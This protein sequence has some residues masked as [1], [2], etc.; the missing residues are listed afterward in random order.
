MRTA[1]LHLPGSKHQRPLGPELLPVAGHC[2]GAHPDDCDSKAGGLAAKYATAGHK[3]KFVAVT[4]G[5]AGHQGEGGGMLAK[6]RTA[7]ANAASASSTTCSITTTANCDGL[8]GRERRGVAT[9]LGVP[10]VAAAT[11]FTW[12]RSLQL[13]PSWTVVS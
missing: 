13:S 1:T 12:G 2:L 4:N 6:R 10:G 11:D 7:E 3:V 9:R 8:N 5:D